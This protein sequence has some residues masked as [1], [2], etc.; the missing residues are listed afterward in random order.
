MSS[1]I[2]YPKKTPMN[3]LCK[4]ALEHYLELSDAACHYNSL[5]PKAIEF[6]RRMHTPPHDVEEFYRDEDC[7][8]SPTKKTEENE[9]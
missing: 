1:N 9:Q 3:E 4:Q 2:S 5:I 7:G 8:S 6:Y